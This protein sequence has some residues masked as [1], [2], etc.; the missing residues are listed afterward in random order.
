M[1]A[2]CR[3]G[4]QQRAG[5]GCKA[6]GNA[7]VVRGA[8]VELRS[9]SRVIVSPGTMAVAAVPAVFVGR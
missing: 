5:I 9:I 8:P 3:V 2:V 4:V 7:G 6:K 1:E